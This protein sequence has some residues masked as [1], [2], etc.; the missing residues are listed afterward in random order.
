MRP[1]VI[2]LVLVLA[3]WPTATAAN[4]IWPAALLTER[5]LAWWIIGASLVIEWYFV[6]TAFRLSPRNAAWATL[7]ANAMSAGI[8]V[9]L[10]PFLGIGLAAILH[11]SG[12]GPAIGWQDFSL[13]D[14]AATF[15]LAVA[16]NLAI[17]L[18]VFRFGYGL[19]IG[20]RAFWLIAL[21][22]VIT[23]GLALVSLDIVPD[24]VY[25]EVSPGIVAK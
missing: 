21:A 25:R 7:A 24:D 11:Y 13:P 10:V 19:G 16:A 8:G 9:F 2:L 4:V 17:E 15:V 23:V 20:R 18:A 5:L 22:N 3:A 6:A 14:W 1:R 12:I